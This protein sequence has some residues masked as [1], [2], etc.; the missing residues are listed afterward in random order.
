MTHLTLVILEALS[1][2]GGVDELYSKLVVVL[3]F[4]ADQGQKKSF[5]SQRASDCLCSGLDVVDPMYCAET[6]NC[7]ELSHILELGVQI[8]LEIAHLGLRP[9]LFLGNLYQIS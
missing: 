7:V 4:N 3:A 5:W 1:P 2:L 9:I 6:D 8:L